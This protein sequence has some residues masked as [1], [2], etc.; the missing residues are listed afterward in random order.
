[1]TH[2]APIAREAIHDTT[3]AALVERAETLG[4]PGSSFAL[5]LARMIQGC[6]QKPR[7]RQS[8]ARVEHGGRPNDVRGARRECNRP[9]DNVGYIIAP[10][11]T[12]ARAAGPGNAPASA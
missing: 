10:R 12:I 2:I 8:T 11:L 9:R 4:V 3:V 5:V 1:M 7:R 6:T